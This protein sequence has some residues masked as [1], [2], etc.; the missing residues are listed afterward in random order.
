MPS[1]SPSHSA[2]ENIDHVVDDMI[3]QLQTLKHQ[4]AEEHQEREESL[5]DAQA[6]IH[7]AQEKAQDAAE[8]AARWRRRSRTRR[9]AGC[10]SWRRRW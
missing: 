10:A 8:A 4:V 7:D 2:I 9:G 1:P 3:E 5:R 6:K